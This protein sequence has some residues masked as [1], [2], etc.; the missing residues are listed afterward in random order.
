MRIA[1]I[2]SRNFTTSQN[3]ELMNSVLNEFNDQLRL[4]NDKI[5]EVITGG[6]KG[7]DTFA[8]RWA[9]DNNVQLTIYRP[10]YARYGRNGAP[11]ERNKQIVDSCDF[12]IAFWDGSS[13]GT[14]FVIDHCIQRSKRLKIVRYNNLP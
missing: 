4:N 5:V 13:R 9:L 3:G 14:K 12:C 10:D 2:G 1:V 7:A 8:E 6:A 11:M